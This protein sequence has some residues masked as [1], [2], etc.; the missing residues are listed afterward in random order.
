MRH[1]EITVTQPTFHPS[2]C[3]SCG[4]VENTGKA[5]FID[6]GFDINF[7]YDALPD[8]TVYLCSECMLTYVRK[9][10]EII[11]EQARTLEDVTF[12]GTRTD[13]IFDGYRETIDAYERA[14]ESHDN[15]SQS[16]PSAL[17]ASFGG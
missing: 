11:E 3:V 12:G 15:S 14:V 1:R 2:C 13:P 9:F 7:L 8:G 10:M 17:T 4:A 6:L 5:F 16:E